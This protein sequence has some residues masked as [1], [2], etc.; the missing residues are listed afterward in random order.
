M[1]TTTQQLRGECPVAETVSSSKL[2]GFETG[3]RVFGAAVWQVCRGSVATERVSRPIK[4]PTISLDL[5]RSRLGDEAIGQ[6]DLPPAPTRV[7]F[8]CQTAFPSA[9]SSFTP[10]ARSAPISRHH[11]PRDVRIHAYTLPQGRC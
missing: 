8:E 6:T 7:R 1:H 11:E 3:H 4:E 5:S 2:S 9:Q 10:I